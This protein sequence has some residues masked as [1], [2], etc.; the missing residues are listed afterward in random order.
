MKRKILFGLLLLATTMQASNKIYSPTVKTLTTI[1]NNDWQNRPLME[2]GSD[3]VL[4]ISFDELSHD[5][6]RYV[7]H[8][9]RCEADWSES[10][11]V[12]ESDWLEGFNDYPLEEYRNS[13]NT[14]VIYTHYE[15][16]IPNDQCRIRMSG[17][18]RL[19]IYDEDEGHEKVADVEF[20]V[21]E[22]LV[23]LG[24]AMTTNT[25]IDMNL[26]HQQ[27]TMT[28][29]YNGLK[30]VRPE[31]EIYTVVMQNWN[32]QTACANPHPSYTH[33][34]GLVWEHHRKLIFD[35]GNEYHKYE[36]L[37]VSHS[38][39]G[40]D[41][42][43]WDGKRYQ[44]YP[45]TTTTRRNYLTDESANGAFFIRNSDRSESA[46]TCDYVWV[47]YT[48]ES[49]YCGEIFLQ[50]QWTNNADNIAYQMRYDAGSRCYRAQVMQKQ[51]Y[52]SYQYVDKDGKP[53]STEGNF[54]QT[55]NKYQALVYYKSLGDRT[56][57]LVGYRAL[58][59]R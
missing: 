1:V 48:L 6:R 28:L 47:N 24:L 27:I 29:D 32:E 7:C 34:K 41:R 18:Y 53:A 4:Y 3:D 21:V 15:F 25:D 54:F 50:G 43:E 10:T 30:V 23:N 31:D 20:Y 40:I 55:R 17:N 39:M 33:Q 16:T 59:A 14:T 52:Y 46:Y 13:L 2:L 36:I 35:G 57:R 38:T 22:P 49:S 12:F 42:I 8:L 9:T 11:E 51:G 19:S 44:A 58:D 5:A 45:F 37:D 26:S 56:W